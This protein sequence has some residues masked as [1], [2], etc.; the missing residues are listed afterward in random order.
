MNTSKLPRYLLLAIFGAAVLYGCGGGSNN[1]NDANRSASADS[2]TQPYDE[3]YCTSVS[4]TDTC[5]NAD[6]CEPGC[7]TKIV[8]AHCIKKSA[9]EASGCG[10]RT[11]FTKQDIQTLLTGLNCSD[12]DYVAISYNSGTGK[13]VLTPTQGNGSAPTTGHFFS[14]PHLSGIFGVYSTAT[15]IDMYTSNTYTYAYR[16]RANTT[17]I[18]F[19]DYGNVYP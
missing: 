18:A 4:P 19:G 7:T 3:T 14:V 2:V 8:Q 15:H 12:A 13:I 17:V 9:F 16:I 6:C 1:A 10:N 11:I 5:L